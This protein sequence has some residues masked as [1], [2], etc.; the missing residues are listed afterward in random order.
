MDGGVPERVADSAVQQYF[1]LAGVRRPG[2]SWAQASA[3]ATH[4]R[5]SGPPHRRVGGKQP[6][7][8]GPGGFEGRVGGAGEGAAA[9]EGPMES[10][11]GHVGKGGTGAGHVGKGGTGAGHVGKGGTGAG[12]VGKGGT[13]AGKRQLGGE[14][15]SRHG[16]EVE[17]LMA[18]AGRAVV[19]GRP[20][21]GSRP[22]LSGDRDLYPGGGGQ[23]PKKFL[24]A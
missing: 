5:W 1:P 12:H 7:R 20:Q 2:G 24:C 19:P 9:R 18:A 8:E 16:A 3:H 15:V 11:A 6:S 13:G 10:G 4:R 14:Y 17:R 21:V 23:R 22:R